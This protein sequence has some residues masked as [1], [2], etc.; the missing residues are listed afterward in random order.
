MS[1]RIV[2]SAGEVSGDR[3]LSK[4]VAALKAQYPECEIRGM[5]GRECEQAGAEL[6]V[7]CYRSGA[8]MG[9]AEI[10]EA[11]PRVEARRPRTH[12]LPRLQYAAR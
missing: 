7:D 4:A 3:H 5:A 2:I 8:T 6:L 12:R 9:F 10:V 11:H 1:L